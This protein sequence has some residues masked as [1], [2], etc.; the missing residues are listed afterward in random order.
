M[1]RGRREERR[2]N[3]EG[4]GERGRVKR[5]RERGETPLRMSLHTPQPDMTNN[6]AHSF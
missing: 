6:Y 4:G 1:R 5:S 3:R 2:E